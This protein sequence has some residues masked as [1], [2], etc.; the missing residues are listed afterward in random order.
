MSRSRLKA[1]PIDRLEAAV[2][3]E[4][5]ADVL[6]LGADADAA[7]A[8]DALAGVAQQGRRRGVDP[9]AG[10]LAGVGDLADAQFGGQGLQLAVLA[11]VAGLA[12]AVVLGEQQLDHGPAG[13]RGRGRVLVKT[14]MPSAAG[15]AQ[16]A[17]RF[18]RPRPRPRRCGRRR[19][20]GAP[21]RGR[22]WGS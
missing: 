13:A 19:S 1:G 11:A 12:L 6:H 9:L 14:F 17:T 15:I 10:P 2:L 8:L 20:S 4:Q 22:A 3:R 18:G 5:G 21:R 16:E 7:A